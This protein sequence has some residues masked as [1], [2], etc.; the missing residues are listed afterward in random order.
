MREEKRTIG[1]RTWEKKGLV[2]V[3]LVVHDRLPFGCGAGWQI[4]DAHSITHTIFEGGPY[5][6]SFLA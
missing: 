1:F 3:V 4:S 6:A 5:L 2:F